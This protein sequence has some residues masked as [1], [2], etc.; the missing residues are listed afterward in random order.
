MKIM[1]N[2]ELLYSHPYAY[3]VL[4]L[5]HH[6]LVYLEEAVDE[7]PFGFVLDGL[8]KVS[9]IDIPQGIDERYVDFLHRMVSRSGGVYGVW[10]QME[11]DHNK[12]E[13]VVLTLF[14]KREKLPFSIFVPAE[15]PHRWW[16]EE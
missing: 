2:R 1:P 6:V 3:I 4:L 13:G 7:A 5:L 8:Q 11:L 15:Q 10:V 12:Q 16:V 14:L 9:W